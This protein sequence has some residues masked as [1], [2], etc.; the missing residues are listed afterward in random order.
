MCNQLVCACFDK[1]NHSVLAEK[2][3]EVLVSISCGV[4]IKEL[5]AEL[6]I[7]QEYRSRILGFKC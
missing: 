4:D 7:K 5:K 6:N 1:C 3:V 2:D